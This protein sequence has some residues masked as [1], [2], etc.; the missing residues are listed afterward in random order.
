MRAIVTI[1]LVLAAI[2]V[3]ALVVWL[4]SRVKLPSDLRREIAAKD[5]R[6]RQ[7]EQSKAELEASEPEKMRLLRQEVVDYDKLVDDIQSELTAGTLLQLSDV[8]ERIAGLIQTRRPNR[9]F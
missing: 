3:V 9:T 8:K 7:L 4:I 1:L 2:A 6:I 5:E